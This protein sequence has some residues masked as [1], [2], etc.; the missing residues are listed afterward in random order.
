MSDPGVAECPAG[1][2]SS[3]PPPRRLQH[4]LALL[5]QQCE[6]K[7][8]LFQTLQSELQIYEALHSS[9]KKGPQGM[10]SPAR[11]LAA[12][13]LPLLSIPVGSSSP[14]RVQVLESYSPSQRNR[15]PGPGLPVQTGELSYAKPGG[16]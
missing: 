7:Q 2:A 1:S 4:K 9:S 5:Q 11:P 8:Q 14:W 12:S 10:S 3:P 15:Q 13:F 6:E 16:W